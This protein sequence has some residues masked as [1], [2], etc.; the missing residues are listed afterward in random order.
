MRYT[1]AGWIALGLLTANSAAEEPPEYRWS[2]AITLP[3]L[4][5][6]TPVSMTLDSHFYSHTREGW[7]DVRLRNAKGEPVAF[8]IRPSQEVTTEKFR[9]YWPAEMKS[10]TVDD[11]TGL[12]V[13]LGLHDDELIPHGVR[14]ITP[15]KDFEHQVL[16]QFS[17]D[18][19][20]W[21]APG[22]TRLIFD[23]S[24]YVD[25]R[26]VLVP[27]AAGKLRRYRLVIQDITASQ[28][29]QLLELQKRI[30]GG[31]ETDRTET[32][33][34]TRRPF[35]IDRIE[36]YRDESQ[37]GTKRHV[38]RFA[39]KFSL[40]EQ[41]EQEQQ[42][43]LS[44]SSSREPVTDLKLH[45]REDNF[46]RAASV[47]VERDDPNGKPAWHLLASGQLTKFSVG[48]IAVDETTLSI[49]ETRARKYRVIVEN[50][51]SPPLRFSG[52]ELTGPKYELLCLATPGERSLILDY[53]SVTAKAGRYDTAALEAALGQHQT[54]V[55]AD[56]S[57]PAVENNVI[58]RALP[59]Q[60][61]NDT[62]VLF[63]GII[64]L[65]LLLG[66]G[67]YRAGRRIEIPPTQE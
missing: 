32:T 50:R 39:G 36:F 43:I 40:D 26:N 60:A 53:G 64:A 49:P 54:A 2:H 8:L 29:S 67:L 55:Q 9:R 22:P 30:Q 46:S 34:I 5:T 66:W 14:I 51:D 58:E 65:T 63:A 35:R 7:P 41:R 57:D 61:W 42:T 37:V 44:L 47:E 33:A 27:F 10:A 4:T 21:T 17:E 52:M 59:W 38:G 12:Q 18:G 31:K 23:Y 16:I 45:V 6:T 28:E 11:E 13:E 20:T 56:W 24:R 62:R 3:E 19:E 1:F 25:A 48:T 15:L